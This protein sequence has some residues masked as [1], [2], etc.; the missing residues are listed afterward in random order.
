M[1]KWGRRPH[2]GQRPRTQPRRP[3][4]SMPRHVTVNVP[5]I[6]IGSGT[7]WEISSSERVLNRTKD[8]NLKK[9]SR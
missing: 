9:I 8:A 1:G 4:F 3:I 2:P 6:W 5:W 7:R